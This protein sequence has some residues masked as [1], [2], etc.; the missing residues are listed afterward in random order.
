MTTHALADRLR[1]GDR[2]RLIRPIIGVTVGVPTL[3]RRVP[4]V[5]HPGVSFLW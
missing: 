4:P 5:L 2:L 3:K 1:E